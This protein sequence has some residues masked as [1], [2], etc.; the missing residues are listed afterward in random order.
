MLL[1]VLPPFFHP[2]WLGGG[3]VRLHHILRG[4]DI[5]VRVV[6]VLDD[7]DP[8]AA[9]RESALR[10][11]ALDRP[12]AQRVAEQQRLH[13]EH[14]AFYD[15]ILRSLR[16][17]EAV[18]LSVWRTN[19]DVTAHIARILR[20]GGTQVVLG[21]PEAIERPEPLREVA[22]VIVSGA[23]DTVIVP[24][25]R[26]LRAPGAARGLPGVWVHP[27]H[28]SAPMP[29]TDHRTAEELGPVDYGELA[30]LVARDKQPRLPTLVNVGC[31]F[32][33][34]FCTNRLVY[35][36]L[37]KGKLEAAVE[38]V[39]ALAALGV[40]V[41]FCDATLNG[42][43]RQFA[44]LCALL[45]DVPKP[46]RMSGNWVVDARVDEA[47]MEATLAAGFTD[48]FF[49]LETGND[50]LRKAMRKPGNAAQVWTALQR[51]NAVAHDVRVGFGVIAG[52]PDET[53]AE[54]Y[55]TDRKSVV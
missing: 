55:D 11:L 18:L 48:L 2:M 43:P 5:D 47:A 1:T 28:P 44:E 29:S 49:G 26:A 20:A 30:P 12:W 22:D 50:R 39:R 10:T 34:G 16:G 7:L 41:E 42:W 35:P 17:A 24:L 27:I 45:R 21:G 40:D 31:V 36:T 19:V 25:V 8:P 37:A 14:P 51:A 54:F 46:P 15:G 13:D 4:N 23:G 33:C 9:I 3:V 53:E 32:N 52:W 6:R 38:E